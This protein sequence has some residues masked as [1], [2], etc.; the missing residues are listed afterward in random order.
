MAVA[1]LALLGACD[2]SIGNGEGAGAV[3]PDASAAT[4]ADASLLEPPDA[5]VIL[6]D[7]APPDARPACVE[8]D[9]RIEDPDTGSCYLLFA[10]P[11]GWG[12]AEAACA[13]LGGHLAAVT[14]LAEN[15]LVSRVVP[16]S[17]PLRDV[18]IGASDQA[19]EGRFDWVSGDPFDFDHWRDGEP[20]DGGQNGED[21]AVLEGDENLPGEGVQWDDRDCIDLHSYLCERL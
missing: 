11:R 3:P 17:G 18:W 9:D 4:I 14:T 6:P 19:S 20:N 16:D 21:C 7:A 2:A 15:E 8:G 5:A 10:D 1:L 13:A 12:E